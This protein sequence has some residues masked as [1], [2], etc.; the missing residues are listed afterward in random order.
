[1]PTFLR[2]KG[3]KFFVY[4]DEEDRPHIHIKKDRSQAKF[5]LDPIEFVEA[6]GFSQKELNR[7]RKI[8]E[9]EKDTLLGQWND[10]FNIDN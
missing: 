10:Y 9:T 1:M 8:L 4:S 6:K 3:H 2:W 5:W 7:L